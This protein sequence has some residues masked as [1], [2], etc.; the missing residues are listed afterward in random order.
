[1]LLRPAAL[2]L[3][4]VLMGCHTVNWRETGRAWADSLC[5]QDPSTGCAPSDRPLDR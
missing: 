2:L 4:L 1:M 3:C 5:A